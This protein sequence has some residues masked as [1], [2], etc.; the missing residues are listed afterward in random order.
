MPFARAVLEENTWRSSFALT[1]RKLGIELY[2]CE[3]KGQI[4]RSAPH[5][6]GRQFAGQLGNI[7]GGALRTL[8]NLRDFN[9]F[10]S[11]FLRRNSA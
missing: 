10:R 5:S 7:G 1:R 3:E 11:F 8:D 2:P 4:G 6:E 9:G